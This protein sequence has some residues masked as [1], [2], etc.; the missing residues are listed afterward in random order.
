MLKLLISSALIAV[1]VFY[2]WEHF[3]TPE[4]SIDE[5]VKAVLSQGGCSAEELTVLAD[6]DSRVVENTLKG[7]MVSISGILTRAVTKGVSSSD[8]VLEL[9]GSGSR[10]IHFTSDFQQFTRMAEG[11]PAR[12]LKFQKFGNEM[13][14]YVQSIRKTESSAPMNTEEKPLERFEPEVVFREGDRLSLKGTLQH[15]G[16]HYI[17]FQLLEMPQR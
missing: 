15:V 10:K 4:P 13:V 2:G 9:N 5:K 14:L 7:R 1:A 16:K 3:K 17:S 12:N 11:I 8:L 6:Q